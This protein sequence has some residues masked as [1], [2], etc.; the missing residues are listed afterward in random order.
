MDIFVKEHKVFDLINNN[1]HLL[2]VINR[3]GVNLGNKDKTLNEI[4]KINDIN[5]DFFL[6]IVNTYNNKDYFPEKELKSFSP[7]MIVKYLK[8]THTYYTNYMLPKLE[9]LLHKLIESDS[10]DSN[11]LIVIEQFYF[12]YKS[13]LL[14]HIKEEEEKVFPLVEK[15]VNNKT[16]DAGFNI[17][18][19]EKEHSDV[20]S[21]INDLKN[22]I[23][24]YI[25]PTYDEN[26]CYEFLVTLFRF[27]K[28]IND[29]ARIEDNILIP[30]LLEIERAQNE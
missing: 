6:A 16:Y 22:L 11:Q 2:P 12:K 9:K 23:I 10:S 21:K 15:M 4:C 13:E 24:K 26:I 14:L 29:H 1:Y 19:Y 28:D 3:F 8:K 17:H 27:E 30:Q 25:E 18:S 7:L 5:I 20:D